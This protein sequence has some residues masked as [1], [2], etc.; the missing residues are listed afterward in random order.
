MPI[1]LQLQSHNKREG[2]LLVLPADME[3]KQAPFRS[4]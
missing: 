1:S 3:Y 2:T 4:K